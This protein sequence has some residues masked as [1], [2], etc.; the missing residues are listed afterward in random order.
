MGSIIRYL[1]DSDLPLDQHEDVKLVKESAGFIMLITSYIDGGLASFT[2]V[3]NFKA[4]CCSSLRDLRGNL[5]KSHWRT[6]I[7]EQG[8]PSK[9]F[10]AYLVQ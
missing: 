3:S 2:K 5:W 6:S 10:L 4:S 7:G 9:L 8:D 1:N